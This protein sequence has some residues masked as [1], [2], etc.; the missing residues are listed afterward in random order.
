MLVDRRHEIDV[1]AVSHDKYEL[2]RI[3]SLVRMEQEILETIRFNS[4]N[5]LLER[6]A[7]LSFEPLVLLLVPPI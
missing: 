3:P 5:N 2:S 4:K 6:D 1:V 7:A